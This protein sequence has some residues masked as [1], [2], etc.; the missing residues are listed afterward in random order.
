MNAVLLGLLSENGH[1]ASASVVDY[2]LIKD[3]EEHS[4]TYSIGSSNGLGI[5]SVIEQDGNTSSKPH[6]ILFDKDTTESFLDNYA[7]YVYSVLRN[8][9]GD[10]VY[11]YFYETLNQVSVPDAGC[12]VIT[13]TSGETTASVTEVAIHENM[14]D[15]TVGHYIELTINGTLPGNAKLVYTKPD[16]ENKAIKDTA[17]VPNIT[18]SFEKDIETVSQFEERQNQ[19]YYSSDGTYMK[20]NMMRPLNDASTW[21]NSLVLVVGDKELPLQSYGYSAG[22]VTF[23]LHNYDVQDMT[24]SDKTQVKLKAKGETVLKDLAHDTIDAIEMKSSERAEDLSI[25]KVTYNKTSKALS[26]HF[27]GNVEGYVG[28]YGS[29]FVLKVDSKEY[30]LRDYRGASNG[31]LTFGDNTYRNP[32]KHIDFNGTSLQIKYEPLT[33]NG[34]PQDMESAAGKP[35]A[36]TGFIDVE[37]VE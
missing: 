31:I 25:S 15:S 33:V 21:S 10:K 29:S 35:M 18:D 28:V 3:S 32:I 1:M 5:Y 13:S 27:S 8:Q 36:S 2:L 24:F 23:D 20:V 7:P 22:Y 17:N 30:R 6:K 34:T 19:S 4:V 26:V 11:L 9:A 16:D 12:F 14:N 37:I